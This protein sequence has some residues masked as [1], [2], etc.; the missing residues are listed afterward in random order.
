MENPIKH[1]NLGVPPLF[2]ETPKC[3]TESSNNDGSPC[4]P[5]VEQRFQQLWFHQNDPHE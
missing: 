4:G 3:E 1:G 2:L 5:K